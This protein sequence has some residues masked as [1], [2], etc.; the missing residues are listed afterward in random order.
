MQTL[1]VNDPGREA[2][3]PLMRR[4]EH[5]RGLPLR[6]LT[7]PK[8]DY[9]RSSYPIVGENVGPSLEGL[10]RQALRL[11]DWDLLEIGPMSGDWEG[12][13]VLVEEANRLSIASRVI[14]DDVPIICVRGQWEDYYAGGSKSFRETADKRERRIVKRHGELRWVEIR[15][16]H[17]LKDALAEFYRVEG[18]GWKGEQ[19]TSIDSDPRTQAFFT[20]LAHAAAEN[21]WLRLYLLYCEDRCIAAQ[22]A[23]CYRQ[24]LYLVKFGYD[25]EWSAFSPGT[26]LLKQLI[27]RSFEDPEIDR[28]DF[29][30]AIKYEQD[31]YKKYW[32]SGFQPYTTV[33][34]FHP[35]SVRAGVYYH[36]LALKG[37]LSR[38]R[39]RMR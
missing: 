23:L 19:G 27:R 31:A 8:N 16:P 9:W 20:E 13:D 2:I 36:G 1:V 29:F 5:A 6:V 39:R 30:S 11:S 3:L 37:R 18:S 10:L 24:I 7:S 35:K 15:D 21:G 14:T 33:Q 4:M 12:V 17:R 34:L 22:F 38:L 25:A 26:L 32:A 28:V